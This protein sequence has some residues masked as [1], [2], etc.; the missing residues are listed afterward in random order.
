MD[1]ELLTAGKNR[2]EL[3]NKMTSA[4]FTCKNCGDSFLREKD[5][6]KHRRLD[7]KKKPYGCPECGQ[8]LSRRD[9]LR[10]HLQR[11][12]GG[13]KYPC[14]FCDKTFD[15]QQNLKVH[16]RIH[17]G[18]RPY[19]CPECGR[20]FNQSQNLTTHLRVHS[21]IKPYSCNDCGATFRFCSGYRSHMSRSHNPLKPAKKRGRNKAD[22]VSHGEQSPLEPEEN[23]VHRVSVIAKVSSP[24]SMAGPGLIE[25]VPVENSCIK[26]VEDSIDIPSPFNAGLLTH[27]EKRVTPPA[28]PDLHYTCRLCNLVAFR[29]PEIMQHMII[30][31]GLPHNDIFIKKDSSKVN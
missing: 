2:N 9:S 15:Q 18:E 17:S 26:S 13:K 20:Q 23:R 14:Q 6:S 22:V 8:L 11:H 29:Q 24:S 3:S 30:V 31:H 5:L 1:V 10:Q 12:D 28:L 7:C 16:L 19:K 4:K 25:S 27:S 21:G